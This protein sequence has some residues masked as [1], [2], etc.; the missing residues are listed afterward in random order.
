MKSF[1]E[2]LGDISEKSLGIERKDMPQVP[3]VEY[4]DFVDYARYHGIRVDEK[5][6]MNPKELLPVQSTFKDK[7]AK[8]LIKITDMTRPIIISK[9]HY[10]IDGHHR[11]IVGQIQDM[12]KVTCTIINL[13]VDAAL[14]LMG[15]YNNG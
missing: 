2:F 7:T 9:D 8:E 10:V 1:K 3:K 15:D 13:N 5:V 14:K 4:Q 11:W 12:K 6:G